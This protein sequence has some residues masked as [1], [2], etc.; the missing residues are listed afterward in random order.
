MT[1]LT[2]VKK[3]SP[4]SIMLL[5]AIL[6]GPFFSLLS[7]GIVNV[8]LPNLAVV[9][10][11]EIATVQWISIGYLM[12][13]P[14]MIPIMGNLGGRYGY[15][16]IHNWGITLFAAAS[17]MVVFSPNL[18]WMTIFRALQGI[19]AAMFQATNITLVTLRFPAERRG[20]VLGL[21][22]TSVA[23]GS[24]LGP[25]VGGV[26]IEWFNWQ[27]M[28]L[29]PVPFMAVAAWLAHRYIPIDRTQRAMKNDLFGAVQ[30]SALIGVAMLIVSFG[31]QWGWGSLPLI[32]L[33][34]LAA[35]LLIVIRRWI[36]RRDKP[37]LDRRLFT[38]RA[39]RI[40]LLV[41]VLSFVVALSIQVSA[42]FHLQAMLKLNPTT[43]G[44]L[45]T[46]YPLLLA[47]SGPVCG[48]LSDRYGSQKV[49]LAG[50]LT[51]GIASFLMLTIGSSAGA[52]RVAALL[53]LLGFGMGMITSPNYSMV[54]H[55]APRDLTGTAGS[56]AA[57]GR[58]VGMAIGTTV[59]FMLMNIWIPRERGDV[60][61]ILTN[62]DA[63]LSR[64]ALMG[65]NTIYIVMG[66][67]CLLLMLL[68]WWSTKAERR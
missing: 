67:I 23:A 41:G 25:S 36:S 63:E 13:I 18:G 34:A 62:G 5:L 31:P 29:V 22:S 53:G 59:G 52:G 42:P 20:R 45:M 57:L 50:L 56:L 26:L 1:G 19:G 37:F 35:A 9:F 7:I 54:M 51:M 65:F 2:A 32:L 64:L 28:F 60:T 68:V 15:D 33:Y 49:I 43:V 11:E 24:M 6:T 58:T 16:T 38:E 10:G 21:V 46:A 55:H 14:M 4:S 17:L 3:D 27:T 61:H 47:V 39:L 8:A 30:F 44:L 66:L 48:S 40:G 12:I